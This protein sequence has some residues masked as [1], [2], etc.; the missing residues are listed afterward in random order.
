MTYDCYPRGRDAKKE[1][2]C[3]AKTSMP[4]IHIGFI[5]NDAKHRDC[6]PFLVVSALTETSCSTGRSRI[7]KRMP[8]EWFRPIRPTTGVKMRPY[9]ATPSVR[10]GFT[11]S[12]GSSAKAILGMRWVKPTSLTRRYVVYPKDSPPSNYLP[13]S[14]FTFPVYTARGAF[15]VTEVWTLLL[16]ISFLYTP[17]IPSRGDRW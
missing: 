17:S 12:I 14:S 9:R 7:S 4:T 1:P 11:S 6:F 5:F 3:I 16:R 2:L 13:V 15:R 8:T 10:S